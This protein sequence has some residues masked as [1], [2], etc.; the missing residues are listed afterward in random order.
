MTI[1]PPPARDAAATRA[2]ASVDRTIRLITKGA[3]AGATCSPELAEGPWTFDRGPAGYGP[4]SSMGDVIPTGSPR[5][6][7]LPA[8][9][10]EASDAEL[11]DRIRAAKAT[12]GDRVVVLG[13]FYQRDEVI[14]HADFTGDSFQLANAAKG[15]PDAEAIVF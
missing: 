9:Y 8:E 1:A 7:A 6:G 11:H 5:Q 2:A 13:H 15:R 4:G 12:L 14:E 3:T 10:R